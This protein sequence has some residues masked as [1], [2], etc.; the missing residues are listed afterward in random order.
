MFFFTLLK[1]WL[2]L[3]NQICNQTSSV[4]SIYPCEA[5][6][7]CRHGDRTA[8]YLPRQEHVIDFEPWGLIIWDKPSFVGNNPLLS[9]MDV[10][11]LSVS[12]SSK[13]QMWWVC[14]HGLRNEAVPAEGVTC[15]APAPLGKISVFVLGFIHSSSWSIRPDIP[16]VNCGFYLVNPSVCLH[17]SSGC[18][19]EEPHCNLGPEIHGILLATHPHKLYIF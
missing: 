11:A 7:D 14:R 2:L 9:S 5:T 12:V 8:I 1:V 13:T 3:L 15:C 4:R 18:Q 17:C 19:Q 10:C 16:E 6:G